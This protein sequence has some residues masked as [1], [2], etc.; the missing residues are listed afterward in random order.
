[1]GK[2]KRKYLLFNILLL[3]LLDWVDLYYLKKNQKFISFKNQKYFHFNFLK[4]KIR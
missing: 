4:N 2:N 1:M 3:L